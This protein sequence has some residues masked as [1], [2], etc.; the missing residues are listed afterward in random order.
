[1]AKGRQ[2]GMP[3]EEYWS[4]F[5]DADCVLS[6][7]ECNEQCGDV[8]EF[9]C[10]YGIFTEA[11]A[12]RTLGT[13]F[14]LDVDPAMIEATRRKVARASLPNVQVEQRDF[15]ADGCGRPDQSVG[16]A[17]LF[18]LLHIEEPVALL[19]EAHRVLVPGGKIGIIHWNYDPTTPRGPS[20]DIRPRPEQCRSWAEQA[21]FRFGR[22]EPLDCCPYHYGLVVQR[23]PGNTD[24][25]R[26]S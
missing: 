18:N 8:L 9:G 3:S 24:A 7:L 5:F 15:L 2:S 10:G 22:F 20:M 17:M 12:R 23:S 26:S 6:N 11:V 13:V 4:S 14:A 16:Y 25:S 21:G 1:M 19:R